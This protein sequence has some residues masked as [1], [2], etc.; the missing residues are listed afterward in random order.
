MCIQLMFKTQTMCAEII[1]TYLKKT[2][3]QVNKFSLILTALTEMYQ[4]NSLLQNTGRL[5]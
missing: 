4:Q 1:H 3:P 2:V 5:Q